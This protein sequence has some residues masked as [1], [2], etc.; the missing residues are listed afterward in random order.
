VRGRGASDDK[1]TLLRTTVR[2]PSF[3]NDDDAVDSGGSRAVAV[4]EANARANAA[5]AR[6]TGAR[7]PFDDDDEDDHDRGTR[8]GRG[9]PGPQPE[10]REVVVAGVRSTPAVTSPTSGRRPH[11]PF[12]DDDAEAH[13]RAAPAVR[14]SGATAGA[15]SAASRREVRNPFGD[16]EDEDDLDQGHLRRG[17]PA[18][19]A[20]PV[21]VRSPF[22][23]ADDDNNNNGRAAVA[24]AAALT[25]SR[26]DVPSPRPPRRPANPFGE[27]DE[28]EDTSVYVGEP[29][30]SGDGT[31]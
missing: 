28:D 25:A 31:C 7:S 14:S 17:P 29:P 15:A 23:D 20:L 12:V 13:E 24:T 8:A 5:E 3:A 9:G 4:A 26:G 1:N 19:R 16:D 6:S 2:A 22:D 11:N 10:E 18:R 27:S 30:V 21:A